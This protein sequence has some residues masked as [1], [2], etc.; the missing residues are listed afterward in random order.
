MI[1]KIIIP[2]ILFCITFVIFSC[3]SNKVESQKEQTETQIVSPQ[4]QQQE[5]KNEKRV[6]AVRR[7]W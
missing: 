1:K 3:A 2:F 4:I 7:L 6:A 5:Q